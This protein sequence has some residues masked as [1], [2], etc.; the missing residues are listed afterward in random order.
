[1]ENIEILGDE[2]IEILG[3]IIE[4]EIDPFDLKNKFREI[5]LISE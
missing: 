5:G 2:K 1:L 3:E 4:T